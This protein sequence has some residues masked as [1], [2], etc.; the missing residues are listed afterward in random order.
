M[1]GISLLRDYLELAKKHP[2]PI[3]MVKGHLHKM[4][5][6]WLSEHHDLRDRVNRPLGGLTVQVCWHRIIVD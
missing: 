2:V 1:S 5:G 6:P 3:R 4:I